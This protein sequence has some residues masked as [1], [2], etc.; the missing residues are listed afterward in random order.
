MNT[1]EYAEYFKEYLKNEKVKF[2]ERQEMGSFYFYIMIDNP[3]TGIR[4]TNIPH[5]QL[6]FIIEAQNKKTLFT[7]NAFLYQ[8]YSEDDYTKHIKALNIVNELNKNSQLYEKFHLSE[9]GRVIRS[10][11]FYLSDKK[12]MLLSLKEINEKCLS[13]E[14]LNTFSI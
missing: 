10:L 3:K 5:I 14:Y 12:E 7:L 9:S 13:G 8:I 6:E 1:I 2:A 4:I 11:S